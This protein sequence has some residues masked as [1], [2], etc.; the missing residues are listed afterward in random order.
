VP[1]KVP[2]AVFPVGDE[3]A[4]KPLDRAVPSPPNCDQL[5]DAFE[6]RPLGVVIKVKVAN[7]G[8]QAKLLHRTNIFRKDFIMRDPPP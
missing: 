1:S 2:V 7:A 4:V 6:P 3:L 8:E 5:M